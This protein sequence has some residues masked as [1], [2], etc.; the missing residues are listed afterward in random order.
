MLHPQQ[1]QQQQQQQQ[2]RRQ[3]QR[4][5]QHQWQQQ[6]RLMITTEFQ[7]RSKMSGNARLT[8]TSPSYRIELH[9]MILYPKKN[10]E[11]GRG[12]GLVVSA[13]AYCAEDPSSN[14]AGY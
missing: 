13:L 11:L 5:Q 7:K 10:S 9:G 14:P 3:H 2:N 1:Q 6:Q 12:G 8:F 4:Q